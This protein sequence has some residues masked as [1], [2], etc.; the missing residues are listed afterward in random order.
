MHSGWRWTCDNKKQTIHREWARGFAST[1]PS[2]KGL[3]F[4]RARVAPV[5]WGFN[6][7]N[8]LAIRAVWLALTTPNTS[9]NYRLSKYWR[10]V[11]DQSF[12]AVVV[13]SSALMRGGWGWRIDGNPVQS[14]SSLIAHRRYNGAHPRR[15]GNPPVCLDG[16][17]NTTPVVTSR[18]YSG[19]PRHLSNHASYLR[20]S[21]SRTDY[22]VPQR[23]FMV[24]KKIELRTDKALCYLRGQEMSLVLHLS[25]ITFYTVWDCESKK[26]PWGF[27]T[28]SPNGLEFLIHDCMPIT[29][30]NVR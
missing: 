24:N 3:K 14:V 16:R 28:F 29:R 19:C 18:N 8:P 10:H 21:P 23:G 9:Q 15:R 27:L 30:F 6:F 12:T 4:S 25:T 17:L 20:L 13:I 11:H 22:R 1:L 26:S 2:P 5:S 7:P